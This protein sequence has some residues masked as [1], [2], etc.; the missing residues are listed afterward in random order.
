MAAADCADDFTTDNS[1]TILTTKTVNVSLTAVGSE[2]PWDK[3]ADGCN[4][5]NVNDSHTV[6]ASIISSNTAVAS[7]SPSSMTFNTC[8]VSQPL[9]VTTHQQ[10]CTRTATVTI[11]EQSVAPSANAV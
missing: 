2:G 1:G 6:T 5:G 10:V 9:T 4:V 11:A 8:G 3:N 7:V